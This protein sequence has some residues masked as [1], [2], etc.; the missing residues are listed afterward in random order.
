MAAPPSDVLKT[1]VLD[2]GT[3]SVKCG[4]AAESLPAV[5]CPSVVGK[6]V[7]QRKKLILK[8]T[9]ALDEDDEGGLPETTVGDDAVT[10]MRE[11][12]GGVHLHWPITNG[13]VKDW[14][15]MEHL[16]NHCFAEM[17]CVPESTNVVLTQPPFNP[18]DSLEK[19]ATAMFESFQV[20]R[21]A[22]VPQGLCALYA[23]GRVTGVVLDSGDGV[24]TVSPVYD[25]FPIAHATNRMN[26]GGGDVTTHMKRLLYERGYNFSNAVDELNLRQLKE[27]LGW[28]SQD[29]EKDL[30][31][32]EAVEKYEMPDGSEIEVGRERFRC[33]EVLFSPGIVHSEDKGMA[34]FVAA[35]VQSC[36]IDAR[37]D[38][39]ANVVLSGGNTLFDGFAKRLQQDVV[40]HFPGLFA[41]TSVVA[42][43]DRKFNVWAG[44][45]VL[46]TLDSFSAYYVTRDEYDEHGPGVVHGEHKR[47][48]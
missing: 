15:P 40:T 21:L 36:G 35:A 16:I 4:L 46:A 24:T 26:V 7:A 6:R 13:V 10:A 29:Y 3:S 44:A 32:P 11:R 19:W 37:R 48:E 43:P 33:T 39:L 22:V 30:A 20:P 47:S 18:R 8:K 12:V 34:E 23:S 38:L 28:V 42:A 25:S 5:V 41:S 27:S 17:E 31:A 45:S 1:L 2:P 14:D 9:A